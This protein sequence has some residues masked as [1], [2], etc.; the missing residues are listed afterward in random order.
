MCCFH[1]NNQRKSNAFLFLFLSLPF[2]SF[3]FLYLPLSSFIFLWCPDILLFV[4]LLRPPVSSSWHH[5]YGHTT[6]L[7]V[8]Q[9]RRVEHLLR[10]HLT[11]KTNGVVEKM[12]SLIDWIQFRLE[13]RHWGDNIQFTGE[14]VR[15][16][17]LNLPSLTYISI[18]MIYGHVIHS[19]I[20]F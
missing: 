15:R 20:L 2:S 9:P 13:F 7:Q 19:T 1:V 4:C 16:V 3:L 6:V 14:Q 8:S 11:M 18:V 17:L 5:D 10:L 12:N